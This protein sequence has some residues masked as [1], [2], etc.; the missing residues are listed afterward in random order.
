MHRWRNISWPRRRRTPA[1]AAD[2]SAPH[3]DLAVGQRIAVTVAFSRNPLLVFATE[4]GLVA[5]PDRCPHA[6]RSL[7]DATV[8]RDRL[9]CAAHGIFFDLNTGRA[10]SG[11]PCASLERWPAW[12]D[13]GRLWIGH[14][15]SPGDGHHIGYEATVLPPISA[16][17]PGREGMR[18]SASPSVATKLRPV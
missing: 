14:E 13:G 5:V 3:G 6:G 4:R 8:T 1:P 7:A 9:R 18:R 16:P 10:R 11:Q 15:R 12:L 17:D 2:E